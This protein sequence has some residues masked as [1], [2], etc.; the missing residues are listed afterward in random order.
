MRVHEREFIKVK[1]VLT[2]R[3]NYSVNDSKLKELHIWKRHIQMKI[4]MDLIEVI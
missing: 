3:E 2:L 1:L 4:S